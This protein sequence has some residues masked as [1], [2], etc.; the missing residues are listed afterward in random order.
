MPFNQSMK[1]FY[2]FKTCKTCRGN[3]FWKFQIGV[4]G[5]NNI[6]R[7]AFIVEGLYGY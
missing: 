2:H 3:P 5:Q 6:F 1:A 7:K 4:E